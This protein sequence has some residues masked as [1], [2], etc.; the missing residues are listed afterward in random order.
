MEE[1]LNTPEHLRYDKFDIWVSVETS[2]AT[3]GVTDYAQGQLSDVVFADIKVSPGD[4][5]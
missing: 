4:S 2:V 1:E 3:I 5:Q